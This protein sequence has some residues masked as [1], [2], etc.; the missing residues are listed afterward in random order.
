MIT[1]LDPAEV[2]A[3]SPAFDLTVLGSNFMQGAT[4]QWRGSERGTTF[5]SPVELRA[6]ITADDVIDPDNVPVTVRNPGSDG[7]VS[8]AL[9]F[10]VRE[11][12]RPG[13]P[14][15]VSVAPDGSPPNG[16]S[17]NGGMSI[18]GRVAVFASQASNL[19]PDDTND[20]WDVFMRDTC[21]DLW[22]GDLLPGCTPS[23]TRISVAPDG[24]QADGD[25][26]VTANSPEGPVAVSFAG[27]YVAF[28]SAAT[29]LVADDTNGVDD[30]FLTD[31]CIDTAGR[32]IATC[33]R[34]TVRVSLRDSGAQSNAPA[35]SP[36]MGDSEGHVGFVSADSNIVAGDGNG[37]ADVFLRDVCL[38]AGSGC[39]TG[40]RR[41]SVAPGNG[42]ANGASGS[43]AFTGRYV[44]FTS[45]A[46]NLVD[47]DTN[48]MVDVFVRDTC[49][50]SE[51]PCTPSTERVSVGNADVQADGPSAE[52]LV[53]LPMEGTLGDYD[54]RFVVFVSEA[55][56]LVPGDTN[57]VADV[58][59]RDTC[60]GF[61]ACTPSTQRISLTSTG[62]QIAGRPS[63]QPGHMRWDGENVLFATAADG[64]VPE[65][66]NG[67]EDVYRS[68]V[69]H[70]VSTC[71]ATSTRLSV[72]EGGLQGS[73][74]SVQPRGNHDPWVGPSWVTFFSTAPEFWPDVVPTPYYGA[75]VRTTTY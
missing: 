3:G 49:I 53:A 54:G 69:C 6:A 32:P 2:P 18:L 36:A 11:P 65:D 24:S 44:A 8:N 63:G 15:P 23:T 70:D 26:G 68:R 48:G 72:G 12:Q 14:V 38:G 34:T 33:T 10:V 52:P 19:V 21:M 22:T 43:P 45:A 37:V 47:G 4:V 62:Q 17:I 39:T 41:I 60:R 5:V 40:T 7:E 50:G 59:M 9:V 42:D 20:A 35:S 67:V 30:V 61:A 27:R 57:G 55:A 73:G 1:G 71:T 31:I 28:I 56:N 29:N 64:V 16:P 74:P 66:T 13:A 25:S 75:I 51:T 58:F 46:S